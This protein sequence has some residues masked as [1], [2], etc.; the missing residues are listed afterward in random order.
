MIITIVVAM[1]SFPGISLPCSPR[2]KIAIPVLSMAWDLATLSL[3]TGDESGRLRRW[4]DCARH[5]DI[6]SCGGTTTQFHVS[7]YLAGAGLRGH[8]VSCLI[9][10]ESGRWDLSALFSKLESSKFLM[11]EGRGWKT[12]SVK[13]VGDRTVE[14]YFQVMVVWWWWWWW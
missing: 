3:F 7:S 11:R 8:V 10:A 5:Q 4:G 1:S 6:M 12:G 14:N 2:R 9:L 13:G